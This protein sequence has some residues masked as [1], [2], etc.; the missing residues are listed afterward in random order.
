[1]DGSGCITVLFAR[2][3]PASQNCATI[4]KFKF[5]QTSVYQKDNVGRF[6]DGINFAFYLKSEIK[7]RIFGDILMF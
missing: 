4:L 2:R 7:K 1:V 5:H 3:E 6:F